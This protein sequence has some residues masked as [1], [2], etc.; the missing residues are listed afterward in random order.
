M[1]VM[2]PFLERQG[3][4]EV[5]HRAPTYRERWGKNDG[6]GTLGFFGDRAVQATGL[7]FFA[8]K[9]SFPEGEG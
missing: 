3:T 7:R 4:A 2:P 9:K 1:D 6:S 8:Y 5:R